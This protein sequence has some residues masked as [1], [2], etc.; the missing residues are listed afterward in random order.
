MALHVV[1]VFFFTKPSVSHV[2]RLKKNHYFYNKKL[3]HCWSWLIVFFCMPVLW[4]HFY[5]P[6]TSNVLTIK[7]NF[8]YGKDFT[9]LELYIHS[10]PTEAYLNKNHLK[11]MWYCFYFSVLLP[12]HIRGCQNCSVVKQFFFF[13]YLSTATTKRKVKPHLTIAPV[14]K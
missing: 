7:Y 1:K 13:F 3:Q 12:L 8:R 4:F 5:P 2:F 6:W 14:S 9:T 10:D 11:Q